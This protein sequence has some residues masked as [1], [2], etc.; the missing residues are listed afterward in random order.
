[1]TSLAEAQV[2]ESAS[3]SLQPDSSQ[4]NITERVCVHSY[5]KLEGAL[6][7]KRTFIIWTKAPAMLFENSCFH[8]NTETFG[9][10]DIKHGHAGL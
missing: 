6:A 1:M 7:Q 3:A 9:N 2:S 4:I 8:R 10:M 5:T